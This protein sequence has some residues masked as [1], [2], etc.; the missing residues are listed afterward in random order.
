MNQR[1]SLILVVL[2][3]AFA[4]C[5]KDE[6]SSAFDQGGSTKNE[7]AATAELRRLLEEPPRVS[8]EM[9]RTLARE[10]AIR[11]ADAAHAMNPADDDFRTTL[12][13]LA[14]DL[15]EQNLVR[16]SDDFATDWR[17]RLDE[18]VT[19]SMGATAGDGARRRLVAS[20]SPSGIGT[21]DFDAD[22]LRHLGV[23]RRVLMLASGEHERLETEQ[24][25]LIARR[26]RT[27]DGEANDVRRELED[28][29]SRLAELAEAIES[30]TSRLIAA[31]RGLRG[32]LDGL[33][34]DLLAESEIEPG[35]ST[36][37]AAARQQHLDD[38]LFSTIPVEAR[39]KALNE[40]P[41]GAY[42]YVSPNVR[43]SLAVKLQNHEERKEKLAKKYTETG[44]ALVAAKDVVTL[45]GATG[46]IDDDLRHDLD[47]GLEVAS[48]VVNTA[49][50]FA[51]GDIAGVVS[52]AARCLTLLFGGELPPDPA[53][54]R[55]EQVMDALGELAKGQQHI[56]EM[57]V[58][59]SE[60]SFTQHQQVMSRLEILDDIH[61]VVS[62]THRM[63]VDENLEGLRDFRQFLHAGR[64]YAT[65]AGVDVDRP[66]GL[67]LAF[68]N[69]EA[70]LA[71]FAGHRSLF[72][73]CRR[74]LNDATR[75]DGLNVLRMAEDAK[76]ARRIA[77]D[78]GQNEKWV[79]NRVLSR[80][81]RAAALVAFMKNHVDPTMHRAILGSMVRPA[82]TF[83]DLEARL[84]MVLDRTQAEPWERKSVEHDLDETLNDFLNP[85]LVDEITGAHAA[86]QEYRLLCPPGRSELADRAELSRPGYDP[87]AAWG[88]DDASRFDH[89]VQPLR[90]SIR[91]LEK[92]M[93]QN[94]AI[95]GDV[96]IPLVAQ[97]GLSIKHG[98][99]APW[100]RRGNPIQKDAYQL[101]VDNPILRENAIRWMVYAAHRKN[102]AEIEDM[103]ARIARLRKPGEKKIPVPREL[104][105][106]DPDDERLV[107]ARRR[108]LELI[109]ERPSEGPL[110]SD[111]PP[112]SCLGHMD[113]RYFSFRSPD[114]DSRYRDP[115]L[116]RVGF[117]RLGIIQRKPKY[118]HLFYDARIPTLEEVE[119]GAI[120]LTVYG[121]RLERRRDEIE[122]RLARYARVFSG[123][124][125]G[126]VG[127]HRE[128]LLRELVLAAR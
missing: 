121:E 79:R 104:D 111:N 112:E 80:D 117:V 39:I 33:S 31:V 123:E 47:K 27:S 95:S 119:V 13:S 40:K 64:F 23:L 92:S 55:H 96:L 49:A 11:F 41:E 118:R 72:E 106:T 9:R 89:F 73:R 36:E 1:H 51:T 32:E 107:A 78:L 57:V 60:Q 54:V 15:R 38:A 24:A 16:S 71:H 85:L 12:A 120:K 91:L 110:N 43:K 53:E 114:A 62:A 100:D 17:R 94:A 84:D 29:D 46:V 58:A 30:L 74:F 35:D 67:G 115:R 109:G 42:K 75:S 102:A 97:Y 66:E 125:A 44:E 127:L 108:Y 6:S 68:P 21:D 86:L 101:L 4:A 20:L 77:E 2:L 103:W 26:K 10:V 18:A 7:L 122:R 37:M 98:S 28:V 56:M 52:G 99:H 61:A 48:E 69:H 116:A 59:L 113:V 124:Q 88:T 90:N 22:A 14:A 5:G 105:G 8:D 128:L 87:L 34:T 65:G 81:R 25:T 45:L 19:T 50:A 3:L 76:Q 63:A 83:D 126:L 93:A 82:T 70:R